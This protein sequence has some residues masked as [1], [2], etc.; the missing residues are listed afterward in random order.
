M[1]TCHDNPRYIAF[2]SAT[3]RDVNDPGLRW[4]HAFLEWMR[5]RLKEA[6]ESN[7]VQQGI[8]VDQM[9]FTAFVKRR[10][11]ELRL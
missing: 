11:E 7:G 4:E 5:D 10:A 6:G 2:C 9:A 1:L 8:V 3:K